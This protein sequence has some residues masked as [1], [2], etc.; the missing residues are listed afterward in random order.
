[1]SIPNVF[2]KS[3][4]DNQMRLS[5]NMSNKEE[6]HVPIDWIKMDDEETFKIFYH[7]TGNQTISLKIPASL[8]ELECFDVQH[9]THQ[10]KQRLSMPMS[11]QSSPEKRLLKCPMMKY[12]ML[13]PKKRMDGMRNTMV[14]AGRGLNFKYLHSTLSSK[15]DESSQKS[16]LK[17][18]NEKEDF[19]ED[20]GKSSQTSLQMMTYVA[21]KMMTS[22]VKRSV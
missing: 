3:K 2:E 1:M 17:L 5:Q 14:R 12:H 20:D 18:F 21:M 15:N 22:L 4:S 16:S 19:F 10:V 8:K 9:F 7:N 6:P 13:G 11:P